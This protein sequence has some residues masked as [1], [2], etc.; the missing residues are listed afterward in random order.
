[1]PLGPGKYD[2]EVTKLR[3]QVQA[4]G[5]LLIVLGGARGT[6]FSAQLSVADMLL[7]PDMLRSMADQIEASG[8]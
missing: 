8:P 4:K 6:G 5:I 7:I 1:M 2:E 3:D